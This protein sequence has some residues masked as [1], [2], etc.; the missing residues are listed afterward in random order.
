MLEED[1][2]LLRIEGG[3]LNPNISIPLSATILD[4]KDRI[5]SL[6]VGEEYLQTIFL[7]VSPLVEIQNSTSCW[8]T[9]V[10]ETTLVGDLR[11]KIERHWGSPSIR[12]QIEVKIM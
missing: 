4:L 9:W 11:R 5:R 1:E 2:V 7:E 3:K 6:L 10:R 12:S 8:I